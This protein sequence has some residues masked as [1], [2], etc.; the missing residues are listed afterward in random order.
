MAQ[1][2]KIA[3]LDSP[4]TFQSNANAATYSFSYTLPAGT[5]NRIVILAFTER[6]D[7][8]SSTRAPAINFDGLDIVTHGGHYV[9]AENDDAA[10]DPGV[11]FGWYPVGSMAAGTYTIEIDYAAAV[12]AVTANV[13]TLDNVDLNFV[14]TV[15]NSGA[16]ATGG[17][18]VTSSAN[19]LTTTVDRSF[20]LQAFC[21]QT[22]NAL[23]VAGGQTSI[24]QDANGLGGGG[25]STFIGYL[26]PDPAG[27][28]TFSMTFASDDYA[29]VLIYFQP[30]RRR[31]HV[32]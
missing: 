1:H 31:S 4:T 9:N 24:Y 18:S 5:S 29:E 28:Q 10:Q 30:N 22:P 11:S 3:I 20:C 14:P 26:A 13:F 7:T 15:A 6:D 23:T 25:P 12:I 32:S 8:I 19:T 17:N 16:K 2:G 27:L 21:T